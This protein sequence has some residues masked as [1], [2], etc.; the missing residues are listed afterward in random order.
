MNGLIRK[1]LKPYGLITNYPLTHLLHATECAWEW[2]PRR[3][4]VDRRGGTVLSP[5]RS[6]PAARRGKMLEIVQCRP[7]F[8]RVHGNF[9]Q[10]RKPSSAAGSGQPHRL[11]SWPPVRSASTP[12]VAGELI[13]PPSTSFSL[14]LSISLWPAGEVL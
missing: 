4:A 12:T 2:R 13:C 10:R 7:H 11:R 9:R 5:P 8:P 1:Y 3:T 14:S 6:P